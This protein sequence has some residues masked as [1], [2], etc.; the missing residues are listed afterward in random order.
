MLYKNSASDD[1]SFIQT[2]SSSEGCISRPGL[3]PLE[4][5]VSQW[6]DAWYTK[7]DWIEFDYATDRVFLQSL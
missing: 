3:I 5:V 6:K 2:S 1:T 7:F 4:I